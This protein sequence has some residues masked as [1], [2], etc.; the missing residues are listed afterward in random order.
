MNS[1]IFKKFVITITIVTWFLTGWPVIWQSPK[2]P[3]EIPKVI[4]GSGDVILL[5]DTANG[6]IPSGW[7]CISC[8]GGEAFYGVFPRAAST[9]GGS[10]VGADTHTH[11]LTY[12][13]ATAGANDTAKGG[14]TG[15]KALLN[16]HTHTW[17]A[18]TSGI[19]DIRPP[20]KNLNFIYKNNPTTLPANI[21]GIFDTG[22]LP[23]GWTRYSALDNNY[24]R[25]FSDGAT[26]GA[27]THSHTI[28]AGA[29]TSGNAAKSLTDSGSGA[30]ASTDLAH[31][32]PAGNTNV[33]NA[34]NAPPFVNVVFAYNS[35]G[36]DTSIPTGLI[37]FFDTAP[38]ASWTVVSDAAPWVG[39]FLIGATTFGSTGGSSAPHNHGGNVILTSDQSSTSLTNL[40]TTG[41]YT[42][43]HRT[44][45]HAVTYTI[46]LKDSLPVYRDVILAKYSAPTISVTITSDGTIAYGT[47]ADNTSK[48]T[49]AGDLNDMQTVK[50]D[51]NVTENFNIKG[52]NSASWTL[53]TSSGSDQY[54]HKYCNDTDNDC[55]SPPTSYSALTTDYQTLDT[56]IAVNG[57]VD[58][59][60]QITT[61]NPSSVYSQQAVDII[62]QAVQQ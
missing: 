60:L 62:I 52:Q 21:I 16:T 2:I 17:G 50:N 56:G 22:S 48:S 40:G 41:V 34:N 14:N 61:P 38:P 1:K 35:S 18:I 42:G 43:A 19:G 32:L 10:T 9:Y 28:S 30:G 37:A 31:S 53:S 8:N 27:S 29:I 23:S 54:V 24:L 51:G 55:S 57:T 4:A 49:L 39:N 45:S 13:S 36:S 7:T 59:Q 3:P 20:F 25:G 44:H 5:W 15:N 33:T 47:M 12:T 58:I 26:G 46:D 6:A 11:A